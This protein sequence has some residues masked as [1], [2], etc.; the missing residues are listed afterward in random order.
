MTP[1]TWY[2]TCLLLS[3]L[4]RPNRWE[5]QLNDTWMRTTSVTVMVFFSKLAFWKLL[6][7]SYVLCPKS[8]LSNYGAYWQ[9]IPGIVCIRVS[10]PHSSKTPS[11]SFLPRPPSLNLETVQA[12]P[13]FR[14]Y[15]PYILV[16]RKPP[17]PRKNRI[18][19][20]TPHN[21]KIFHP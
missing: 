13:L 10:A 4:F 7:H 8:L 20:W 11:P 9:Q 12:L 14:Q 16:C 5:R 15:P 2:S 18:F 19:Q 3:F 6:D 21:I 1:L 17:P